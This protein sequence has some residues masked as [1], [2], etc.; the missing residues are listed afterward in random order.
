MSSSSQLSTQ[1][2]DDVRLRALRSFNADPE[3]FDLVF[4]ANATAAIKLVVDSF[5]DATPKGFWYGYHVE[6]HTSL[7]GAREVADLGSKCFRSDDEVDTW[8]SG[9]D[10]SSEDGPK[11]FAFP[12]Q[13]NMNGRRFPTRWCGQ[14]RDT[15]GHTGDVYSLLDAASLVST[16]PLDLSDASAAPDFTVLSFYK[17]F[18]FPDL[19]ALIVRKSAGHIFDKRRFFGGG[20]VDLVLTQ[21]MQWHAK[22]TSIHERLE[23]GTLPF[24][25]IIALDSALVKHTRLFGSMENISSHTRFLAKNLY[26][27]LTALTHFNGAKVFE[28]YMNSDVDFED[29]LSL[30]HI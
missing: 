2:I 23:D 16:S 24:H 21:G 19:G 30:I 10:A 29:A 6:S 14:I 3:E 7:V 28:F 9:M 22:K 26:E 8:I 5:R 12:A 25:S 1:R 20:T 13:S 17:I 11:L 4:V 27:R 15:N 18:G